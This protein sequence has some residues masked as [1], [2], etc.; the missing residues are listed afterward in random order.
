L[1]KACIEAGIQPNKSQ[2]YLLLRLGELVTRFP[3]L[4]DCVFFRCVTFN[5]VFAAF[6]SEIFNLYKANGWEYANH[7]SPSFLLK[8][9]KKDEGLRARYEILRRDYM[10]V[11]GQVADIGWGMIE[12]KYRATVEM[13]D[14]RESSIPRAGMGLFAKQRIEK[15]TAMCYGGVFASAD[16]ELGDTECYDVFWATKNVTIIGE[17]FDSDTGS[18]FLA[19][20]ANQPVR[21]DDPDSCMKANCVL[22]ESD[23]GM[24]LVV[25]ED[26]GKCDSY[27]FFF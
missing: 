4:G 3:V 16:E 20:M 2:Y 17:K 24:Y 14:V 27:I 26:L 12:K 13:F 21:G 7:W 5:F 23:K 18:G 8:T 25:C 11:L 15:G 9:L 1:G 6:Q 22:A 10:C 19:C